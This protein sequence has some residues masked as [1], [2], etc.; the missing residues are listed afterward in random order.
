M[1]NDW[2]T[3]PDA[4]NYEINSE[5]ICRN[6]RTKKLLKIFRDSKNFRYYSLRRKDISYTIKRS[7]RTLRNQAEAA[8]KYSSFEPLPSF[9]G[10]YEM[11]Q[12]GILRNSKSK[13]IIKLNHSGKGYNLRTLAGEYTTVSTAALLW[14]S[15]GIIR[16]RRFRP[17]PC[18]IERDGQRFSFPHMNACAR[19]LAPMVYFTAGYI[20]QHLNRRDPVV[21]GWQV[22]YHDD[23]LSDV[24]WNAAALSALAKRQAKLDKLAGLSC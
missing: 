2:L 9:N 13:Q 14:E 22:T 8:V 11:N 3:I 6:R 20:A 12:Y 1:K 15:H 7:P 18:T 16:K 17:C 23:Y 24:K 19:F 10:T 4:P 21:F 5:L